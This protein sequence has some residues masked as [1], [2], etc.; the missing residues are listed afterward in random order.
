MALQIVSLTK[1][2]DG[3]I[4]AGNDVDSCARTI[5]ECINM[6]DM[7]HAS[8][9]GARTSLNTCCCFLMGLTH[10]KIVFVVA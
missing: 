10:F 6:L 5:V 1:E 2:D 4:L 9:C 3:W 7:F 8:D